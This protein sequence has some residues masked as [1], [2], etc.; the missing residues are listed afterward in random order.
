MLAAEPP[1]PLI[2][3]APKGGH[4]P[5]R[6]R[7][8]VAAVVASCMAFAMAPPVSATTR[9][10]QD[11]NDTVGCQVSW[12]AAST[13]NTRLTN[14]DPEYPNLM[15]GIDGEAID[16]YADGGII[17]AV[18]PG[19]GASPGL[20]TL[21][22][23]YQ[24]DI[25]TETDR[26]GVESDVA[27]ATTRVVW[28]VPVA[29]NEDI[30]DTVVSFTPP[31]GVDWIFSAGLDAADWG[32]PYSTYDWTS[33]V[34]RPEQRGRNWA[35]A[36][37]DLPSGTGVVLQFVGVVEPG[38]RLSENAVGTA[39]LTGTYAGGTHGCKA[40]AE[41]DRP[42]AS[43]APSP[44][45]DATESAPAAAPRPPEGA[46]QAAAPHP[47]HPPAVVAD[48]D[49]QRPVSAATVPALRTGAV[50]LALG[51]VAILLLGL[52]RVGRPARVAGA[53]LGNRRGS[54]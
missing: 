20:L 5:M 53:D 35:I 50:L 37:G 28:Q 43:A 11:G 34:L 9:V 6:S 47:P 33:P 26:D 13:L 38:T 44:T 7:T 30:A 2:P 42:T 10:T 22:H 31:D 52:R 3:A 39:Q 51:C 16:G 17:E 27:T 19:T 18:R 15:I 49:T 41:T 1:H 46:G 36:I 48:G 12:N 29:S 25:A 23:A 8:L 54:H 40:A 24:G 45:A 4:P 14:N 21:T 32:T